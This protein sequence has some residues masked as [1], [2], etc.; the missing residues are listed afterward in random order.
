MDNGTKVVRPRGPGIPLLLSGLIFGGAVPLHGQTTEPPPPLP[1]RPLEFPSFQES[2]LENGLEIIVLEHRNQP[3]ASARL[4][5]P[6]GSI[7]DP[8]G[9]EGL[10][11]MAASVLTQGTESRT[12]QEISEAIEG[13]GGSL[14]ASAGRDFFTV[15]VSGLAEHLHLGM[16]LLSDVVRNPTF[17]E[18]EVELE[19]VRTLSS[20]R[21]QQGQ[22]TQIVVRHFFRTIYGEDHPYGPS[23]EPAT[24]EAITRD[25]LADF[26]AA[27]LR[28]Q[29]AL[30]VVAG[31][32]D[33]QEVEELARSHLGDWAAESP[34]EAE[35]PAP[36]ERRDTRISLVHRP[37][38][39][40]ATIA[41]GHLSPGPEH[42][43]FFAL[44]VMNRVLGGGTDSR[45]FRILREERGW[46]YGSYSQLARRVHDGF[47]L[48][49]AEV[50]TEVTDSTV[51][52]LLGQLRRLRD[53]PVPDEEVEAAISY[54]AGS[55]PLSIETASQIAGQI[56]ENRLLGLSRERLLEYPARIREVTPEEVRRVAREHLDPDRLAVVVVGD[57]TELLP[58]LEEVGPV[59]LF[60][61]EGSPLARQDLEGSGTHGGDASLLA[62]MTRTYDVIFQGD[63]AGSLTYTLDRDGDVWVSRSE[64]DSPMMSQEQELR[65][66][67]P[68]M[69]AVSL[70]QESR[71]GGM[72]VR[73]ELRIQ[74]GRLVGEA[75]L[76]PQAGGSQ[77]FDQ[78][79]SS[80]VIFPGMDEYVLATTELTEGAEI[81]LLV[82]DLMSGEPTSIPFQVVG[83]ETVTVEA[84]TFETFRVEGSQGPTPLVLNLR[85]EAPH[86]LVRQEYVGAPLQVELRSLR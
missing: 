7:R 26:H 63:D 44:E 59:D 58:L 60:D 10:A 27:H 82:F 45:L 74:D 62:P 34:P 9:K 52:E 61:V 81:S 31:D 77:S 86:L 14:S 32:V 71:Q 68:E 12:A 66:S 70:I 41:V 1:E 65:F 46:T 25:D 11:S 73:A 67:H 78:A 17:P 72:E 49:S 85:Q 53:E 50:R 55:F 42:P 6:A 29:G 15:S 21:A 79:I 80:E 18:E 76:P 30:L 40:Q 13:V 83:E 3:V 43:D 37:A 69:E 28:P 20:L 23:P 39:V 56:A 54:L 19:R 38:S 36:P 35:V 47:L 8:A 24:V 5:F 84:G 75:E 4:Y 16:D 57:A 22:P 2:S 48:A 51:V 64:M 33:L